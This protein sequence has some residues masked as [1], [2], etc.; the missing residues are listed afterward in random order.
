MQG[1][2]GSDEI[3]LSS[4]LLS[5]LTFEEAEGGEAL[6][7]DLD[8]DDDEPL[9]EDELHEDLYENK[10]LNLSYPLDD[11][12]DDLDDDLEEYDD[13]DDT[14]GDDVQFLSDGF[15]YR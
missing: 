12:D 13:Y 5:C 3:E 7:D 1:W 8:W 14:D 9:D 2:C 4:T 6:P 11:D 15:D 10:G